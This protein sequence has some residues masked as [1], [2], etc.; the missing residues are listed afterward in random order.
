MDAATAFHQHCLQDR[1]ADAP[2]LPAWSDDDWR[3]L[4]EHARQVNLKSGEVLIRAGDA[5]GALY[6]VVKG[7]LEV[8]SPRSDALGRLSR[9]LPGSVI[10][11]IS[12]F[13]GLPRSATVWATAPTELLKLDAESWRAFAA[14]YPRQAVDM[15]FALGRV[16]AYRIRRSEERA[17]HHH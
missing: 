6:F 5:G 16:L 11:E 2:H 1:A 3:H 17:R 14:Q 12:F 9:E 8:S 13:D 4:F 10:G 15:L 7:A